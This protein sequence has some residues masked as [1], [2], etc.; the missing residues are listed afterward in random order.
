MLNPLMHL[1][2]LVSGTYAIAFLFFGDT[3]SVQ[4]I[5]LY[6]YSDSVFGWKQFG[7]TTAAAIIAHTIGFLFRGKVGLVFLPIAMAAGFYSWLY[8]AVVYWDNSLYF[9][10]LILCIPNLLFWVWYTLQFRRRARGEFEA[11]VH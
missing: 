9:Q 5:S 8:A 1:F 4:A 7:I 2:L 11:F 6:E 10:F 3:T